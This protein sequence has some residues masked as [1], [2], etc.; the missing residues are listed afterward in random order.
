MMNEEQKTELREKVLAGWSTTIPANSVINYILKHRVITLDDLESKAVAPNETNKLEE[1]KSLLKERE[2][3]EY[4]KV[5]RSSDPAARVIFLRDFPESEYAIKIQEEVSAMDD[6]AWKNASTSPTKESLEK[7]KDLFPNG[8]H[9]NECNDLLDDLPFVE[10]CRRN[11]IEAYKEYEQK[12]PGK[13]TDEIRKRIKDKEDDIAWETAC[14][15]NSV[16]AYEEYLRKFPNGK[17]AR[18]ARDRKN[19]RSDKELFLDDLCN[20]PNSYSVLQI[21]EKKENGTIQ[22]FDELLEVF[23]DEQVTAIR[24]YVPPDKLDPVPYS[25]PEK[26]HTEVYFWGLKGTG[27]T[28]AIGSIIGQLTQQSNI[29]PVSGSPG[30]TY[31]LQLQGLF[32]SQKDHSDC[33]IIRLPGSTS[34]GNLPV[35]SFELKDKKGLTH[36]V[37]IIDVAGEVFS[38]IF[39][40]NQNKQKEMTGDEIN[41]VNDLKSCLSN[42]WNYKIHFFIMEYGNND[43]NKEGLQKSQIMGSLAEYFHKTNLFTKQSVA[44]YILATKCDRIPE[45][46]DRKEA[47]ENYYKD[48]L[49]KNF[50]KGISDKAKKSKITDFS[51]LNYSIGKVFAQ[52]LCIFD[53]SDADKII[54]KIIKHTRGSKRGLFHKLFS[55]LDK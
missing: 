4:D 35:L 42:P 23:N 55:W 16:A 22:D 33:N 17:H 2:E 51:I 50:V 1:I 8:N 12:Y 18:D 30:E 53:P 14:R 5:M 29:I 34:M 3:S 41:A 13:H 49:W 9:I 21:I 54:D 36:R 39:K 27:K 10:A 45:G 26:N 6:E 15:N 52:D 31:L 32:G 7:Y 47:I 25:L 28:C 43:A 46:M 44:M 11:T 40:A 24:N 38:G 20:D 37:S 48:S 19:N